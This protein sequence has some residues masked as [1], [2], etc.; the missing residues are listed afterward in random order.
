MDEKQQFLA[1][2]SFEEEQKVS[3]DTNVIE[4]LR[5]GVEPDF[6]EENYAN[7]ALGKAPTFTTSPKDNK[8]LSDFMS[9]GD[10][11]KNPALKENP[12]YKQLYLDYLDFK[13]NKSLEGSSVLIAGSGEVSRL[14]RGVGSVQRAD[15][16]FTTKYKNLDP[17]SQKANDW[18]DALSGH[19]DGEMDSYMKS[20][21]SVMSVVGVLADT[22]MV[23][24][25]MGGSAATVAKAVR[26]GNVLAADSFIGRV[27]AKQVI[28]KTAV[29]GA[30][31]TKTLL[32]GAKVTAQVAEDLAIGAA[33]SVRDILINEDLKSMSQTEQI[34]DISKWAGIG[35]GTDLI[36]NTI[37][38][39]A[40]PGVK[41]L[42]RVFF[43]PTA[44]S[45]F[46]KGSLNTLSKSAEAG[47]DALQGKVDPNLIKNLKREG[48]FQAA[49]R[50]EEIQGEVIKIQNLKDLGL[51]SDAMTKVLAMAANMKVDKVNDVYHVT[52]DI[53]AKKPKIKKV[54]TLEEVAT[55]IDQ[56]HLSGLKRT[57]LD[58]AKLASLT[59]DLKVQQKFQG[60]IKSDKASFKLIDFADDIIPKSGA[61]NVQTKG[62]ALKSTKAMINSLSEGTVEGLDKINVKLADKFFDNLPNVN[63]DTLLLPRQIKNGIELKQ[64]TKYLGDFVSQHGNK[65][66]KEALDEVLTSLG[67]L[68]GSWS[69]RD[70]DWIKNQAKELGTKITKQD[71]IFY[72]DD[73]ISMTAFD[74]E[75]LVG[76]HI[77]SKT[78]TEK[79]FS[80]FLNVEKN[81]SLVKD[82]EL[83]TFAV[84]NQAKG[85]VAIGDSVEELL[86]NNPSLR[87]KYPMSSGPKLAFV[88]DS[89]RQVEFNGQY[90]EGSVDQINKYYDSYADTKTMANISDM[91]PRAM[92]K[93]GSGKKVLV[94]IDKRKWV[95]TADA[96]G[97]APQH[98]Q[99][100]KALKKF[101]NKIGTPEKTLQRTAGKKGV[102]IIADRAGFVV[103]K[104]GQ[105]DQVFKSFD[106]VSN[107]VKRLPNK[108]LTPEAMIKEEHNL[109]MANELYAKAFK[110]VN[111]DNISED[112]NLA[113]IR[114]TMD[115]N[116]TERLNKMSEKRLPSNV[117]KLFGKLRDNRSRITSLLK[118]NP[119]NIPVAT[120]FD[121]V[122]EVE[123]QM[124]T[125]QAKFGGV[126][127]SMN[128]LVKKQ[129]RA[130]LGH[131]LSKE[132]PET[133][134]ASSYFKLTGDAIKDEQ[135]EFLRT[136][137]N[138]F[139]QAGKLNGF[140]DSL[141]TIEN[142]FP[143]MKTLDPSDIFKKD[144]TAV[145]LAEKA[146]GR[147]LFPAETKFFQNM[148]TVDLAGYAY[149]NDPLA[150]LDRYVNDT[151]KSNLLDPAIDTFVETGEKLISDEFDLDMIRK[152]GRHAKGLNDDS[153]TE[154]VKG[155]NDDINLK[156]YQKIANGYAQSNLA[157]KSRNKIRDVQAFMQGKVTELSEES[158]ANMSP[159]EQQV[160]AEALSTHN[161]R[162]N[163]LNR[164]MG[165]VTLSTQAFKGWLPIRNTFQPETHLAPIFGF[166]AVAQAKKDVSNLSKEAYEFLGRKGIF[167]AKSIQS[168]V[169]TTGE[170]FIKK[171]NEL[172]LLAYKASDDFDRAVGFMTVRNVMA[173]ALE[174]SAQW[175]EKSASYFAQQ[176]KLYAA[177][178]GV[179]DGVF[180]A[181]AKNDLDDAVTIYAQWMNDMT[182][183][184][185]SAIN[186]PEAFNSFIGKMF[187]QMGTF[188]TQTLS[189]R[190]YFT[191]NLTKADVALYTSRVVL[192]GFALNSAFSEVTGSEVN[193]FSSWKSMVFAG[194]PLMETIISSRDIASGLDFKV[195]RG[196]K[197]LGNQAGSLFTP[198]STITN[199]VGGTQQILEGDP[200]YGAQKLI[201]APGQG[202]QRG[203]DNEGIFKILGHI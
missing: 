109:K 150:L 112:Q 182:F 75:E 41:N 179:R 133:E 3:V 68:T 127:L 174:A 2:L 84:L 83:N 102:S 166:G 129:D 140:G 35:I 194:G 139:D 71:G 99:S 79:N 47:L 165:G 15:S 80:D 202:E 160:F 168:Q 183:L 72:V 149:E 96:F 123:K 192:G 62:G 105:T 180:N 134:W 135:V 147:K 145:Q 155:L 42:G 164:I 152:M 157:G 195:Q 60:T 18:L 113:L 121:N 172:G 184:N 161:F 58:K 120:A 178:Q 31:L 82:P 170:G 188:S 185:Y 146:Y 141:D 56:K 50:L 66:N 110:D 108:P 114:K 148:R 88:T 124:K 36:V 53:L 143:K 118:G 52:T 203:T 6:I 87:P 43:N 125:I 32:T 46:K 25:M 131:L 198:Y 200:F 173:D 117:R 94:N 63:S 14:I 12:A 51:N 44:G 196:L 73:G 153:M 92:V 90:I 159:A 7:Y 17:D 91:K 76:N 175:G 78:I 151:L 193:N 54:A 86:A 137:R 89:T 59:K 190:M 132:L 48:M 197:S 1:G 130:P 30:N 67:D 38:N 101:L 111:Y 138:L 8:S 115:E 126:M 55:L 191:Q 21:D 177:P 45:L 169:G 201:S 61:F 65:V 163:P 100:E 10:V 16:P 187:G 122:L 26:T 162:Q 13:V 156:M 95:V 119:E 103:Q 154:I 49:E 158:V 98:F 81:Y 107:Y 70:I 24:S 144:T 4:M 186:R 64:Y 23:Q 22:V 19:K 181:I 33:F 171:A 28:K 37:A 189:S 104:M 34:K 20:L 39:V 77:F 116:Y 167:Q 93:D 142:Y 106:E 5:L 97:M 29:D 57:T 11:L 74:S 27:V 85:K 9:V 136:V 199:I 128:K 69:F 176:T 40:L